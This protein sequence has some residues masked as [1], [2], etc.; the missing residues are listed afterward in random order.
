MLCVYYNESKIINTEHLENHQRINTAI[1][2][3]KNN[4]NSNIQIYSNL[5]LEDYLKK[6]TKFKNKESL[7]ISFLEKVYSLDYLIDIKNICDELFGN[8][9][10][11]GDTYFS[12]V[13]YNE[14]I[15]NANILYNVCYQIA[16]KNIKYAYCIIRPPS[17]HS[18]K[19]NF[20][21][22]C[23][24]NQTFLTAK[25]LH[26]I[27]KKRVLILDYDLHHGDGT[28]KLVEY[29]NQ[30]S[31]YFCSMHYYAKYFFPGTGS[32]KENSERILNVPIREKN[33]TDEGYLKIFNSM[34]K[35]FIKKCGIDIIIISNGF[36]GHKDDPMKIM[37]L[38]EKFYI[39]V[40]SYLKTLD[41]PL[42]YILEG[43]YNPITI[44]NISNDIIKVLN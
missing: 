17:H 24:V 19:D 12:N 40:A 34:V 20:S 14:L 36:D 38:T 11:D 28:Q 33:K 2:I 27:Y 3:I 21:G 5:Q 31:I 7:A 37:N 39:E 26:D 16:N 13:T 30:D 29:Y 43:G 25:T 42:I 8:E 9:I 6:L 10:I 15:D 4:L 41:V 23:I 22:F 1:K 18:S 32:E 44:G 35:P